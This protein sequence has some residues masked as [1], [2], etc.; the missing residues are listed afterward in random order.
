VMAPDPDNV[1][2]YLISAR[3]FE[4]YRA[5]FAI[6]DAD[7]TGAVLDC[8][9]GGSSFTARA[10]AVG[11]TALAADPVYA[12]PAEP[13]GRLAVAETQRGS[14]HTAAGADRYVWDFYGDID[15]HAAIRRASAEIFADD[16]IAH[17]DRY[18]PAALPELPFGDDHFDLV[19]SSHFLF[20]YADRLDVRFH[21]AA[22]RELYRVT[23]GEVRIF[24][25]LEQGGRAVPDL[26]ET[27]LSEL[28][29]PCCIRQVDYEFQRGGN[30]MLA[31]GVTASRHWARRR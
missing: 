12:R 4:E 31:L 17:P 1:G 23:R 26:V 8:P 13:A 30:Q 25:L 28:G 21:L 2:D 18:V 10:S 20:T 14:A 24:P 27:V 7:L 9:G 29:I 5:M 15:G 22:L 19:L 6:T 3:S 16:I 11:M